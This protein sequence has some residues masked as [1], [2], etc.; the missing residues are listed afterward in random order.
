[1]IGLGEIMTPKLFVATKAF[2]LHEGK[3]LIVRESSNYADG[4]NANKYDVIGGRLEP[5]QRFDESLLREIKEECGLDATIGKPFFVNEWRPV[6]RDEPWQIVGIFFACYTDTNN[7]TLSDDHDD[8]QWIDPEKYKDYP[9]IDN[10]QVVFE[11][12]L[13][14]NG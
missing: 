6:V 12:Y 1:M 4:S 14:Q 8:Y 13:N 3:V 7:I 11:A 9:I 10:L 2:L 5:G